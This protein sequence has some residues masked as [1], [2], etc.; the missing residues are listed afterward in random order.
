MIVWNVDF[1]V[2]GWFSLQLIDLYSID[3]MYYLVV[4]RGFE[5]RLPA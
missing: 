5:P 2:T 1:Q 4:P 3:L